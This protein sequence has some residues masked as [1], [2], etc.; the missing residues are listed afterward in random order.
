LDV[1]TAPTTAVYHWLGSHEVHRIASYLCAPCSRAVRRALS[2]PG[3]E[4]HAK[5]D[6]DGNPGGAAEL[7]STS[8][9]AG[10]RSFRASFFVAPRQRESLQRGANSRIQAADFEVRTSLESD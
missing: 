6:E 8:S 5:Q 3:R 1:W 9:C 7:P 4:R 2:C 10:G